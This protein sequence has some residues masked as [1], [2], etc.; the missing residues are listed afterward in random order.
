M[1]KDH[2]DK[3]FDTSRNILTRDMTICIVEALVFFLEVMTNAFFSYN[4]SNGKVKR[5]CTDRNI[6]H[7][8]Q[9]IFK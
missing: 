7:V 1:A 2:K 6:L 4:W 9:G 3:Y 5:L 8:S